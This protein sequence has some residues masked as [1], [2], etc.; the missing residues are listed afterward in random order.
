MSDSHPTSTA[1]D[2]KRF[3][4]LKHRA[5]GEPRESNFFRCPHCGKPVDSTK[6]SIPDPQG[7]SKVYPAIQVA[8]PGG[9]RTFYDPTVTAGCEFCG[10][11]YTM[12]SY[13]K[14]FFS[15]TNLAGR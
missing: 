3:R 14:P 9:T 6:A 5:P 10:L 12:S 4:N 13:R 11:N 8:I 2:G 1:G 15:S 7:N